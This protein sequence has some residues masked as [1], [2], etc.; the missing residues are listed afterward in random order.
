MPQYLVRFAQAHETFRKVELQALADI[1][2]V[3][4]HFIK[5]EED[6]SGFLCLPTVTRTPNIL[7]LPLPCLPS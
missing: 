6:V 5:Y 1:A 7:H 3:P 4:V 2:E